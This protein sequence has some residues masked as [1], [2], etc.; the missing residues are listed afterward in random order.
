MFNLAKYD[1][2]FGKFIDIRIASLED[3]DCLISA[4][5]TTFPNDPTNLD[6]TGFK[7]A[8]T[9]P[10]HTIM[11]GY[12]KGEFAGYAIMCNRRFRPWTSGDNLIILKEYFGK[13]IGAYLVWAAIKD[14][15]RPFLRLFVEKKNKGAIRLYRKFGFFKM[16]VKKNH[17]E[18]GDDA[19]IMLK[20]TSNW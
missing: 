2:K 12:Y 16:G 17:Y 15:K 9:D 5:N 6:V 3:V 14:S 19:L 7:K 4:Q 10:K 1:K 13:S 18:N 11:V 8:I 20:Y